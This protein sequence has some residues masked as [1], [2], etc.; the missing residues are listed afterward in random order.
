MRRLLSVLG[1]LTGVILLPAMVF[2]QGATVTGTVK[3]TSGA[4]LPGVTVQVASPALIE[5][6]RE[7]VSDGSGIYRF[8]DLRPGTYSVTATLT[9]FNT[10]KRDGLDI[11]G[12]GTFTIN[13]EMKVGAI[14]ETVTVSGETPVVDLQSTTK[15]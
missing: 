5:R 10:F 1:V 4:V 8:V 6:T 9:G 7:T 15:E 13:A 14:E 12:T 2:A 11:S 3:D